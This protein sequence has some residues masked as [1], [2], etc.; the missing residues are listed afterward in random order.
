MFDEISVF[1]R[2]VVLGLM[3]A[4]PVG[5]VG[6]LCIRRT[7]QKGLLI[8]F[9][10]GFGAAFAD[11]FFSALA[12]LGVTAITDLVSTYDDI[13]YIVGGAFLLF[14]AWHTW[15]DKPKSANTDDVERRYLSH[16]K[17]KI[18]G[19]IKAML[20]S[21]VI[22]LTNPATLFG[23]L[24]V[25]ATFGG[26]KSRVETSTII[27]GI[28]CGSSLWWLMLSGGVSLLRNRFTDE[29]V[30]ILNRITA[31]FLFMIAFGALMMG[32]MHFVGATVAL[33]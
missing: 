10:S 30:I 32:L 24:A 12:V 19:A 4:A 5:P 29:K 18:G 26:L 20:T 1:V 27:F 22:T 9:A 3:V 33:G 14:I 23:V 21:F 7:I 17:L 25:V 6:L 15:H 8:G 2:G 28:F 13:I 11:A 31:V 16:I